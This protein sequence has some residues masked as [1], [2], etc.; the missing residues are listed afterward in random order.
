V[1]VSLLALAIV[2]GIMPAIML[3]VM[4]PTTEALTKSLEA[5]YSNS[6]GSQPAAVP[7]PQASL[8]K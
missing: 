6:G 2:F 1:A 4:N 5:G 7:A 3:D 8:A